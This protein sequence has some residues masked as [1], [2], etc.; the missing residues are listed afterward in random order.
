MCHSSSKTP[1]FQRIKWFL[2]HE[3]RIATLL[4]G[5]FAE[6]KQA[7]IDLKV[8][9][10]AFKA[11]LKYIYTGCLSLGAFE[12][13]QIIEIYDLANQY[14]FS[15]LLKTIGEYLAADLTLSNCVAVLNATELYS[16][17]ELQASCLAFMDRNSS[18]TLCKH[19]LSHLYALCW[20]ATH[21]K[22]PKL[23]FSKRSTIGQRTTQELM[24]K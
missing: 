18:E 23:T 8:P 19:C 1:K 4:S 9:L 17:G 7:K 15:T 14:D 3:V 13:Y 12:T 10:D 16:L 2:W 20:S 22:H 11:I 24:W 21:S 5:A 6:T